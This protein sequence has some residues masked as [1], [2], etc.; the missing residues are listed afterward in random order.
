MNPY[1]NSD[2]PYKKGITDSEISNI[3]LKKQWLEGNH[4]HNVY[5][6]P[7]Q[8]ESLIECTNAIRPHVFNGVMP[9]FARS[10][11]GCN[12]HNCVTLALE[13]SVYLDLA[14]GT[15]GI[16]FVSD[17]A[18]AH[19]SVDSNELTPEQ[20]LYQGS[21]TL[22]R[23]YV[24]DRLL[25][26]V[27]TGSPARLS[28]SSSI[29]QNLSNMQQRIDY[30]AFQ[31][32]QQMVVTAMTGT[33]STELTSSIGVGISE[34]NPRSIP[35]NYLTAG[36]TIKIR[37][38]GRL[39]NCVSASI[40]LY[41]SSS[42]QV[43][44]TDLITPSA[45]VCFEIDYDLVIR[46]SEY[47]IKV[48]SKTSLNNNISGYDSYRCNGSYMGAS[49]AYNFIAVGLPQLIVKGQ[50]DNSGGSVELYQCTMEVW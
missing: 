9:N 13:N 3:Y 24:S 17:N 48:Q 47:I 35:A 40:S 38:A 22:Q 46:A 41:R 20:I 21:S 16:T 31:C 49:S 26:S 36:R 23:G 6:A 18:G 5:V 45:E 44:S 19:V 50:T 4:S 2:D 14:T 15:K 7:D 11:V 10:M 43:A 8:A 30:R 25:N 29:A 34:W 28:T 37:I 39:H 27:P 1:Q 42:E 32:W 12:G 33:T